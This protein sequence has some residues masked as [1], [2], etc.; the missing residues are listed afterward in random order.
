MTA[1][2]CTDQGREA[3]HGS[4]YSHAMPGSQ[5]LSHLAVSQIRVEQV[6]TTNLPLVL[7][8]KLS[9]L[10]AF[11]GRT[12]EQMMGSSSQLTHTLAECHKLAA[13]VFHEQLNARGSKLLQQIPDPWP[14]L[15]VPSQARPPLSLTP[16]LHVVA[17]SSDVAS[18][19]VND[20]AAE[21][22]C[23][24]TGQTQA[25]EAAGCFKAGLAFLLQEHTDQTADASTLFR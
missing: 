23:L 10:L 11:Y 19:L 6:I 25:T 3:E 8:F 14:Q 21:V 2:D 13:R 18:W 17:E 12:V 9:Q 22:H 1:G 4:C 24:P 15:A 5:K 16:W 7:C 20:M